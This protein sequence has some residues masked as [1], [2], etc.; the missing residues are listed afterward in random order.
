MNAVKREAGRIVKE[1]MGGFLNPPTHPEHYFHV[2]VDLR[3][4]PENRGGMSLTAAIEAEWLDGLIK[5]QARSMLENWKPLPLEHADVQDWIHRVLGYFK[6]CY[7]NP[8]L[9][10]PEFWHA[11]KML[12]T[13]EPENHGLH[14]IDDHAGV[15]LIR[16]YYPGFVPTLDNMLSA[17][18]GTKL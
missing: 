3:R 7:R 9:P 14:N 6:R 10:E 13:S 11:D 5:S 12:I 8:N 4:R 15:H 17:Y 1:G 2:Q 16:K 18:W